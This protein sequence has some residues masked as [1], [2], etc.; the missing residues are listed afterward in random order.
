MTDDR[1]I[2]TAKKIFAL[3]IAVAFI[4]ILGEAA[5]RLLA[6]FPDYT[7]YCIRSFP[8]QYDPL[9]GYAGVPNLDTWFILPDF[10]HRIVNNSRGYRDRERAYDKGGRKRIVVLGDS[11]T[12]GWGVESGE[13]FSDVIEK[14]LEGWEVINLAQAGY[15]TD[16]E[17][18]VL[19]S[20]G[21]KYRP[22]VVILLFDRNDVVEGNNAKII[23][24]M[25]PKPF[26]VEE[27]GRLALKNNPVPFDGAYWM[28]K[29]MLAG[30][31][32]VPGDGASPRPWRYWRDRVFTRSHLYNWI[33][34]RLAHPIW[35]KPAQ[36]DERRDRKELEKNME[37]TKRLLE[38]MNGLCTR[39][40]A[41]LLIADVPS[42]YSQ[43]L[44]E[45]CAG[46]NIPYIDL[47]PCLKGRIRPIEHRKV[48]HWTAY[49][50]RVV[51]DAMIDYLKRNGY[52][53]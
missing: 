13:R 9:L 46:Q 4:A 38:E 24:G 19:E 36:A 3:L 52:V 51:A 48:G 5:L 12:W 45:F 7:L 35:S 41:R 1:S 25:Q 53:R 27:D 47:Q 14:R 50:H 33:V 30:C 42:Y 22:D 16:Q 15:S 32:G 8:D 39:N 11:T 21:L 20:E 44:K 49:G 10:K 29:R 26:F 18:L 2:S 23:D 28:Q 34:F 37:L 31:Y 17:L 6:P 40:G 43:L